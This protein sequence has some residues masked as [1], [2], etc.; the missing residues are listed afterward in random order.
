MIESFLLR[1]RYGSWNLW[2]DENPDAAIVL[3]DAN[4]HGMILTGIH[5]SRANLEEADLIGANLE[6]AMLE[7][8]AAN[9]H[10]QEHA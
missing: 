8:L 4:L 7:H 3:D 1:V 6:G 10:I 5:L 9:T 2:R